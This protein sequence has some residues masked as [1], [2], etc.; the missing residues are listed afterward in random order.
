MAS[1][2]GI[3][4]NR[5]QVQTFKNFLN[6]CK[7][8]VVSKFQIVNCLNTSLKVFQ[9]DY[10]RSTIGLSHSSSQASKCKRLKN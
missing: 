2:K 1:L 5:Y 7:T 3:L 4:L 8:I 10:K 9:K 6:R